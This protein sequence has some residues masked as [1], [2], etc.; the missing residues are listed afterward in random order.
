MPK[1]KIQVDNYEDRQK[2]ICIL[3]GL[4]YKTWV[5]EYQ[6]KYWDRISMQYYVMAELPANCI[7]WDNVYDK[8][9]I[10]EEK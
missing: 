4:G 5:E 10:K 7:I 9:P 8:E 2:L 6:P 1:L 3:A